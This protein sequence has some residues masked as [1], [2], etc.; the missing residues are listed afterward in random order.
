MP[1]PALGALPLLFFVVACASSSSHAPGASS[2]GK[3]DPM[4]PHHAGHGHRHEHGDDHDHHG[5]GM[6]HGFDG[7]ESW[8]KVFDAGDRDSWQKPEIVLDAMGLGESSLVADVG[9]GTGYFSARLAKRV[10]KGRVFAVDVEPD[11][12]RY[13]GERAKREGL[14]NVVAVQGAPNDPNL[15]EP[16]DVVLVVDTLHHIDARDAYFVKLRDKL[17]PGGRIVIVDFLPEATMGPP[18]RHRLAVDEVVQTARKAGLELASQQTLP[19]Q[20]VLVFSR[21]TE[22]TKG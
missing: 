20:Y 19:Q 2:V 6:Q 18:A 22:E 5:Q 21:K 15:P 17:R 10:P 3:N 16:V 13:L 12:V 8:A 7:A 9:A 1:R 11:M 4:S 14:T